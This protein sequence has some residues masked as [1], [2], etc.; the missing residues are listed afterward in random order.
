M[1]FFITETRLK[2]QI[3]L[4][5]LKAESSHCTELQEVLKER[6]QEKYVRRRGKFNKLLAQDFILRSQYCNCPMDGYGAV[7]LYLSATPGNQ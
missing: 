7:C 1:A 6:N 3:K 2:Q 4:T 5:S